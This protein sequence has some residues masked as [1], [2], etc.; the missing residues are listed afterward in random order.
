MMTSKVLTLA[1]SLLVSTGCADIA[2]V[3]ADGN[4]GGNTGTGGT[5]TGGA[6]ATGGTTSSESAHATGGELSNGGALTT[7]GT[8]STGGTTTCGDP[9]AKASFPACSAA[10]DQTTCEALGGRWGAVVSGLPQ[11]IQCN[12]STGDENCPCTKASDCSL[13][14]YADSPVSPSTSCS[15]TSGQCAAWPGWGCYCMLSNWLNNPDGPFQAVCV[16]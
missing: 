9:Q 5:S 8:P 3:V 14:C 2:H 11:L 12:C 4:T 13:G 16:N 1:L 6:G 10:K 15:M 7:G